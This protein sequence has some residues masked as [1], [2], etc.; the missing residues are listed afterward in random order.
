MTNNPAPTLAAPVIKAVIKRASVE[1]S[2][3]A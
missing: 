2:E 3:I 1:S